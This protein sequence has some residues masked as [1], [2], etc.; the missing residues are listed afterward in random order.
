MGACTSS[1]LHR[2]HGPGL[3]GVLLPEEAVEWLLSLPSVLGSVCLDG[4]SGPTD[5]RELQPL[6]DAARIVQSALG[7]MGVNGL[8]PGVNCIT[9]T[10]GT[11]AGQLI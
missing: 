4:S 1:Q 6:V 3:D 2:S 8:L 9:F 5:V 7:G 10:N 11:T